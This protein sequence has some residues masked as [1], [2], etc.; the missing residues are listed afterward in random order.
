[1]DTGVLFVLRLLSLHYT[2]LRC[3][4]ASNALDEFLPGK[5]AA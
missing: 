5:D 2:G 1:M 4:D 3:K